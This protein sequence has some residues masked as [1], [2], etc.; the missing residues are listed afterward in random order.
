MPVPSSPLSLAVLVAA[1]TLLGS[2][3]SQED[4]E[5]KA[6]AQ[7][8]LEFFERRVR[9]LLAE[10][11]ERCHGAEQQKSQLRLD[12]RAGWERGGDRGPAL[13]PGDVEGSRLIHAVRY[14]DPEFQM[15]PDGRLPDAAIA[16]LED[17]VR[18]G[19]HDPRVAPVA[20][21]A[22]R[23][24]IDFDAAR[25]HWA[26][27]PLPAAVP[28]PAVAASDW[29]L[30]DLDRFVLAR[31]EAA[32][33]APAADADRRT[34]L[35]RVSLDL[36]GLPPSFEE[37]EDFV[38]DEGQGAHERV[39]DRLLA[40]PAYG[41]RQARWW[42]DL[43]RYADSNGLD[44]NLALGN[45][46]RYR[47]AVVRAFER[48]QPYDEFIT[49]Q[50]AGDLVPATGNDE[51]DRDRLALTGFLALGPKMLAEQD[52]E[53]LVMDV[54]DEQID[55]LTKAVLGVTVSCARCHDHKFDPVTQ[56][57]YYALAGILKSTS[58]FE[59]LDHVS[60]WRELDLS[61][62]A[63]RAARE[64]W[65]AES[66]RV[67]GELAQ[68]ERDAKARAEDAMREKLAPHLL[69]GLEA[70]RRAVWFEAEDMARGNL[71]VDTTQWGTAR[72]P[73]LRT[74]QGGLQHAEW[75]F[76][77]PRA[78]RF[79][80]QV[81][82]AAKESRPVRLSIDGGS[83][84]ERALAETTG[85]WFL[86]DQRW[87][88][89]AE[90]ELAAGAHVLRLER[91]GSI[92]HLDRF[93]LTPA[94]GA[95]WPVDGARDAAL[96]P[97][98]VRAAADHLASPAG[99]D[100]PVFAA[101]LAFAAIPEEDFAARAADLGAALCADAQRGTRPLAPLAR[102]TFATDPPRSLRE[103]AA[104]YATAFALVERSFARQNE[105]R[106]EA[107]RVT[108]LPDPEQEQL[109]LAVLG[110]QGLFGTRQPPLEAEW[111]AALRERVASLR[112]ARA[113]L[114]ARKPP[115]LPTAPGVGEGT[116]ADLAV[117]L[118]GSHRALAKDPTPRGALQILDHCLPQPVIAAGSGRRELAQ[119]LV[120]PRNP[121][122][123]RALVNRVWQTH[124]GRGLAAQPSNLGVRGEAP[125]HPELLDALA[126]EFVAD[127]ASLKRLHRR[128][129]LSRSYRQSA[130]GSAL[131]HERDP[132]GT[133]LS[134]FPRRRLE[135]EAIRDSMLFVAGRLDRTRGG[136]LL[137]TNNR[138]Y[139]TN[140]Q[141]GNAARYDAPRRTLYLPI[142]R[143]AL[144]DM[145]GLFDYGDPS[146]PNDAR[147]R[148]AV[149]TQA[150]WLMNSPV[151]GDTALA[152]AR[153][154]LREEPL[155]ARA[156]LDR[157][158][159]LA[160][161]RPATEA[162]IDRA[163][164][165]LVRVEAAAAATNAASSGGDGAASPQERALALVCQALLCCNEFLCIE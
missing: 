60:R 49:W 73:V 75:D 110:E 89:V 144:H 92:P 46:W 21:A 138:D 13:V 54:V 125:T 159:R 71:I 77:L 56:R 97:A 121:L 84:G 3:R 63:E 117:H 160:L 165:W 118:R 40:S 34:W 57:D 158:H 142:I 98:L 64:S 55:V 139:V 36:C 32:G 23:A 38:R 85:D 82:F 129:V 1:S 164:A 11:C 42:L 105:G 43:A 150:L 41:E 66:Q 145:L 76:T 88:V 130:Q 30:T 14:R 45:A 7:A 126:R 44:E 8:E 162:E 111:P 131:A 59:N 151:V 22:T 19:A 52:K 47:D 48:D 15:P 65:Q 81:R 2:P 114:D 35:R 136:T 4:R 74:G 106:P 133:L 87:H 72:T 109:R 112:D 33:L 25:R 101:L 62:P 16:V 86:R 157:A 91:D 141:S 135:A 18:R 154:L 132:E 99:R 83:L 78:G 9:P 100:D 123:A 156:R 96:V 119:W 61:T 102:A 26:F 147:S 79:A 115:P 37:T 127:G 143:N 6:A 24:A 161:A 116:P 31:L 80:L 58:T 68:I 27:A 10:H 29:P 107:M 153:R 113:Q 134:R 155:D 163:A 20:E 103:L 17:W 51:L 124:F 94:D 50:I 146:M 108:A 122:T 67:D 93:A 140:D 95:P 69:A 28:V 90:L 128:I 152:F 137:P 12:S 148:T 70:M 53:K 149:A 5:A 104:R 39:V 120:D